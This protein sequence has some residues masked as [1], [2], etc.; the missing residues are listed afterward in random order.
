[1]PRSYSFDH[2]QAPKKDTHLVHREE[3][4]RY[5]EAKAAVGAE[6]IQYGHAHAQ[7]E[8]LLIARQMNAQLE[9]LAGLKEAP[10]QAP[11]QAA[12]PAAAAE[13]PEAP[14]LPRSAPIGAL[15]LTDEPATALPQGLWADLSELATTRLRHARTAAEELIAATVDLAKLPAQLAAVAAR[16][17]LPSRA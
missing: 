1:M 7:T 11:K 13:L 14:E 12:A 9:E 10:K 15:P 4:A 5:T 16:H 3:K 8:E 6:K 2:F 17:L